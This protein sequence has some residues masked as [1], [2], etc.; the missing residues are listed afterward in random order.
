MSNSSKPNRRTVLQG[1]FAGAFAGAAEVT[2]PTIA[3]AQTRQKINW[4][5]LPV[6][7][8]L[9]PYIGRMNPWLDEGL[10]PQL[11]RTAGGPAILQL[12]VSGDLQV[13]EAATAPAVIAATRGLPLYFLA[14]TAVATPKAPLDRIMVLPDSPIKK[15]ED[16]K[17][18]S[19]AINQLGTMPDAVLGVSEKVFGVKK[20]DIKIVPIPYP[21]MPQVLA[22][23]QVDAIY[24]FPPADAIAEVNYQARTV[25][26]TSDLVPYLGFTMLAVRREFADAQ[27][28]TIR[29]LIRGMVRMQRWITENQSEARAASNAVLGV[30]GDVAAKVR[31]PYFLA[32]GLTVMPNM[33]HIYNL[34]MAGKVIDPVENPARMFDEYFVKPV[35]RFTLPALAE[36]GRRPDPVVAE[37]LSA[38]YPMLPKPPQEYWASW[39]R[40]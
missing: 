9:A 22:Q 11:V 27:P 10:E 16:L 29:R 7:V 12:M 37:M 25:T 17:G 40:A 23:K 3:R 21:N 33:W 38:S 6:N 8:N 4:G 30:T 14:M 1:A 28:D 32:N 18:R 26:E 34:L 15:F 35:E 13:G 31:M 20:V 39:E 36:L 2:A 24:P 5:F 19:L